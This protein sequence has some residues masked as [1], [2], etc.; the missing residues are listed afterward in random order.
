MPREGGLHWILPA[1]LTLKA[2]MQVDSSPLYQEAT[3]WQD[4]VGCKIP[5]IPV[6]TLVCNLYT[7]ELSFNWES[8]VLGLAVCRIEWPFAQAQ[9]MN[10]VTPFFRDLHL[11]RLI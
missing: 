3:W 2:V 8:Q 11:M 5:P 1:W 6:N 4:I 7:R 9:H 10:R